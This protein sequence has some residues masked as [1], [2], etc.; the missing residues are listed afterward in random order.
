MTSSQ[1]TAGETRRWRFKTSFA[2]LVLAQGA[3]ST[4]EYVGRLWESFP[5]A[6]FL[7]RLISQDLERGFIVINVSVVASGIWC[8]LWPVR[9]EWRSAVSLV[10][11]WTGLELINGIG[12]PLWSLRAG[13]YTPG[14]VTATVLL[15]L[16]VYL[17]WQLRSVARD[18]L[19]TP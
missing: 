11:V 7:S 17:A 1:V 10:W 5:P 2:A 15:P 4:E 9:K 19:I 16:A 14:V 13:G 6:G 12:H 3:H 18:S 8:F